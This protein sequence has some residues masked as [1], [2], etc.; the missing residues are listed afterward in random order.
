MSPFGDAFAPAGPGGDP[1]A[2]AAVHL[3]RAR[4][5]RCIGDSAAAER[6]L[7]FVEARDTHEWPQREAQSGEVDVVTGAVARCAARRSWPARDDSQRRA[8]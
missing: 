8:P 2:R 3:N 6:T 1:F 5:Q 7:R 4:W